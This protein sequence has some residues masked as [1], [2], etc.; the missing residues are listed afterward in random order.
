LKVLKCG[1]GEGLGRS[2]GSIENGEVLQSQGVKDHPIYN[3]T[4]GG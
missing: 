1:A 3:N 4:K 2:G